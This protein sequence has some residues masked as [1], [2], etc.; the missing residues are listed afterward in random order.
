MTS[1][2][3][4]PRAAHRWCRHL[5][6]AGQRTIVAPFA[7]F[8]P[9]RLVFAGELELPVQ[10]GELRSEV[11]LPEASKAGSSDEATGDKQMA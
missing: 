8:L 4:R 9:P 11:E 2:S 3:R 7:L 5:L 1:G 6:I 10:V